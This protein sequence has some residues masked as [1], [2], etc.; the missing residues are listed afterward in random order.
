VHILVQIIQDLICEDFFQY[1]T[2]TTDLDL[3]LHVQCIVSSL[4]LLSLHIT[5]PGSGMLSYNLFDKIY[6]RLACWKSYYD[7]QSE[8]VAED[9]RNI[10]TLFLLVYATDLITSMSHD[11][12]KSK[13]LRTRIYAAGAA[14]GHAVLHT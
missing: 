14:I 4:R 3:G 5:C 12:T 13:N 10:N 11:R 6:N 1:H 9:Y 2:G 8:G 7:T